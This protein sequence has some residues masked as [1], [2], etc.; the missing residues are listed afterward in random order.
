MARHS[1]SGSITGK[2]LMDLLAQM[3]PDELANPIHFARPLGDYWRTEVA[4]EIGQITVESVAWCS[5]AEK[6]QTLDEEKVEEA[7]RA[8]RGAMDDEDQEVDL[9]SPAEYCNQPILKVL[10]IR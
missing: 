3:D 7:E 6:F 2:Q 5:N 9:D 8:L 1:E 4:E 10:I